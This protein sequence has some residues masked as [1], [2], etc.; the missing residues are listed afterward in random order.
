MPRLSEHSLPGQL[1]SSNWPIFQKVYL[2]S[3]R[4]FDRSC[5]TLGDPIRTTGRVE[6][7]KNVHDKRI[8]SKTYENNK[9]I[10]LYLLSK[11]RNNVSL[12]F[13]KRTK[14]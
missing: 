10:P 11:K 9:A 6:F 1:D 14:L 12:S 8:K 3:I 2:P 4:N 7:N 13:L 5:S